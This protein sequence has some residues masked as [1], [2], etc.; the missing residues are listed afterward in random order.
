MGGNGEKGIK[1]KNKSSKEVKR[2]VGGSGDH[3]V[4]EFNSFSFLQGAFETQN[5]DSDKSKFN[6]E[7]LTNTMIMAKYSQTTIHL[8]YPSLF[9]TSH[10]YYLT[11]FTD[12]VQ[13]C[14]LVVD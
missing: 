10:Q 14:F 4:Q 7:N 11:L 3:H 9:G 1:S 13:Y 5:R 12:A 2:R 6:F 8:H